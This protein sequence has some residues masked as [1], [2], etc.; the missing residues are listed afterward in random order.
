MLNTVPPFISLTGLRVN[1]IGQ[2]GKGILRSKKCEISE[3]LGI[4]DLLFGGV[5]HMFKI[6]G[7]RH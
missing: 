1:Q 5:F 6:M 4:E 7:N 2:H 3:I